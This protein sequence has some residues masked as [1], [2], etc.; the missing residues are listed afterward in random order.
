MILQNTRSEI[1][2]H[3]LGKDYDKERKLTSCW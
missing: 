1:F 2:W 3:F